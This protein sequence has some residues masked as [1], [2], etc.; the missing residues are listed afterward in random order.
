MNESFQEI[1]KVNQ[2]ERDIEEMSQFLEIKYIFF[3]QFNKKTLKYR[4]FECFF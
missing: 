1:I 3:F 2:I 4:K